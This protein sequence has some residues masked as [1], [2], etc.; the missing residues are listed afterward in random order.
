MA[1]K[2]ELSAEPVVGFNSTSD[3]IGDAFDHHDHVEVRGLGFRQFFA[4]VSGQ[5][6]GLLNCPIAEV[7]F[8][9]KYRP[10][11]GSLTDST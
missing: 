10:M 2:H 1:A 3:F 9:Q 11:A 4:D 6:E 5:T 8:H 7:G